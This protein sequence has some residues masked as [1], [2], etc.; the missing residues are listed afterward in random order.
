MI[1]L[2]NLKSIHNWL[3]LEIMLICI[4]HINI[5]WICLHLPCVC[6]FVWRNRAG[7]FRILPSQP[8]A[9]LH[10]GAQ[11]NLHNRFGISFSV[12]QWPSPPICQHS[13]LV[14]LDHI[15]SPSSSSSSLSI[16][17]YL[18]KSPFAPFKKKKA[19]TSQI[20]SISSSSFAAAVCISVFLPWEL[21]LWIRKKKRGKKIP[22]PH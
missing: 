7:L 6:V 4:G 5:Y 16:F 9:D 11:G 18:P 1:S 19:Q 15:S 10:S 17:S 13:A 2:N 8:C 3:S 22:V 12:Q 14:F 21:N 20:F